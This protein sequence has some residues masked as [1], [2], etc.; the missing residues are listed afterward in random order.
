MLAPPG[1]PTHGAQPIPPGVRI[2]DLVF[3]SAIGGED[4][5]TRSIPPEPERQVA[6][7]FRHMRTLV[8]AAGGTTA[9]IAKVTVHLSDLA[10]RDLVNAEW[11]R[12]FPEADDRPVR[13]SV[14]ADLRRGMVVQLEFI[15]VLA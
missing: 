6:F 11:L 4:P 3:S 14:V 8:E 12:M 5:A 10:H 9:D 2:G 13:H 7:A 1:V 15:A